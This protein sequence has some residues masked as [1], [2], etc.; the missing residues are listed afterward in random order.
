MKSNINLYL[1]LA[2]ILLVVVVILSNS[3]RF[4]PADE[5][6][7][8]V[9]KWETWTKEKDQMFSTST[10]SPLVDKSTFTGLSYF[11]Y[12]PEWAFTLPW[13]AIDSK[14]FVW[15]ATQADEEKPYLLAGF[16]VIEKQGVSDTL[17]GFKDPDQTYSKLIFFPF[18]DNS[19]GQTTYPTGRFMELPL[20]KPDEIVID[21]NFAFN[22]FCVYNEAYICP[23]PPRVNHLNFNIDAGE[24]FE[25]QTGRP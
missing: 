19:N 17:Y 23:I 22:P 18:S 7:E 13:K 16:A 24:K 25:Q 3:V 5:G 12:K 1:F 2:L 20:D 21:F 8:A 9:Q 6:M 10:R 11:P 4:A 15:L 14:E